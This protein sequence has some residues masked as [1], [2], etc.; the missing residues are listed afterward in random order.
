M[1]AIANASAAFGFDAVRA[2]AHERFSQLSPPDNQQEDWLYVGVEKLS[3]TFSPFA[4]AVPNEEETHW[5]QSLVLAGH[6]NACLVFW[7]G[8]FQPSLSNTAAVPGLVVTPFQDLPA[9][10]HANLVGRLQEAVPHQA[11]WFALLNLAR[12]QSGLALQW[13]S[14]EPIQPAVQLLAGAAASTSPRAALPRLHWDVATGTEAGVLVTQVIKGQGTVLLAPELH[15]NL[16]AGSRFRWEEVQLQSPGLLLGGAEVTVHRDAVFERLT[17][18]EGSPVF[19]QR[20]VLH[21][22]G[23]NA[24]A[25]LW[26]LGLVDREDEAHQHI[27][28]H[29]KAPN[30]QSRQVFKHVLLGEA[31]TSFDGMV[32]VHHGAHGTDAHQLNQNLM[33]SGAARADANPRL[34]IFA[35]DVKCAHGATVGRLNEDEVFYLRTRG[36][37]QDAARRLLTTGFAKEVVDLF[38]SAP[39][40]NLAMAEVLG[41]LGVPV[42]AAG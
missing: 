4:Q 3:E 7:N 26:G 36:I 19:R 14:R 8:V 12:Y 16:Q 37:P 33:L 1:S 18:Y 38:K 20:L 21:L 2:L 25:Y 35:D 30:C 42:K 32:H 28:L 10:A 5:L 9:E 24:Q 40:R 34:E 23:E 6:E 29:H 15:I 11:D 31:R 39:L 17:V 22:A 41:K 13:R 27:R